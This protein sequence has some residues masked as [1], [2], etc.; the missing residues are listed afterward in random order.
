MIA[1]YDVVLG[2]PPPRG[3][4]AGRPDFPPAAWVDG[5]PARANAAIDRALNR[6]RNMN[7]RNTFRRVVVPNAFI[8]L[9]LSTLAPQQEDLEEWAV[10]YQDAGELLG[11]NPEGL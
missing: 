6:L 2:R 9:P 7:L 8:N 5:N 1:P 11:V 10:M 4:P 3:Q